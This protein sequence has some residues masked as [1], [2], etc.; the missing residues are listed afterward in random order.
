M[1]LENR[2]VLYFE[3]VRTV[4]YADN[5]AT[6][7]ISDLAFEKML[8]FLREQY[9]NASSQYSFGV[10]AR[11]AVE[12]ARRQVAEAIEAKPTE[13]IFTSGGSEG[14]SW[15]LQCATAP[16]RGDSIHI[17]ISSIEHHS[18]LNVCHALEKHGINVTYLPVDETGCIS[19][20]AV[21]ETLRPDTR[22][23]S[24]MMANNEIGTWYSLD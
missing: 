20:R 23:V 24:I 12:L 22:L 21:E 17:I 8:P 13:I 5:A 4:I 1:N 9:G 15:V 6:T 14:N 2:A 11:R 7:R 16:W 19:P 3:D 18:V 10:K